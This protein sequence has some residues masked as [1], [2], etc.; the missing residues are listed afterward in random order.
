M[1]MNEWMSGLRSFSSKIG[2]PIPSGQ[3]TIFETYISDSLFDYIDEPRIQEACLKGHTSVFDNIPNSEEWDQLSF[4][5]LQYLGDVFEMGSTFGDAYRVKEVHGFTVSEKY[6]VSSGLFFN[7]ATAY[8]TFNV[9]VMD[10]FNK[11]GENRLT[12]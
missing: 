12:L 9:E 3:K 8:W 7:F 2:K 5:I 11:Y 4:L 1:D 10:L 6:G